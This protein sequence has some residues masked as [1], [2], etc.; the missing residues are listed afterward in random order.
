M[1]ET[2][3]G[4]FDAVD[5]GILWSRIVSIADEMAS[6]LV[7]TSFSTM[8]RESG[9]FSVMLFDGQ[10]R[11]LAQGA[12]GVPS[13]T[14]TGPSTIKGILDIIPAS[15]LR[16]GDVVIT[17]DPWIGTGHVYDINV[18][19]PVFHKGRIVGYCLTVSHLADVGG[20]PGYGADARDV[21]E[22]GFSLPP[23][24]LFQEGV[25]NSFVVDFFKRNVRFEDLVLG[26]L[27]SNVAS[28]NVG[29]QGL[30]DILAEYALDD[31]AEVADGIFAL[32]H[33]AITEQLKTVP[34]GTFEAVL[35]VEGVNGVPEIRLQVAVTV[36]EGGFHY[37]FTGTGPIVNRGVNV[38]IC[39]TRA[40]CYFCF[41][42]LVAPDI[43]NNQAVIDFVTLA[44]PD[45][46]ILNALRPNPTGAR[47]IFGH[48]VAPLVFGALA[49]AL[50]GEVQA[51]SG[52]IFQV[53]LRGRSQ[54]GRDFSYIYFT[55][56]GYG[57]FSDLDG[58]SALPG[59]SNMIGGP[60]E[61][62][63]EDTGCFFL[64]KE[65]LPDTGGAGEFQGGNGQIFALRNDTG[66]VV[67]GAFM[68]SRTRLAARGFRGGSPGAHRRIAVDGVL[69]DPKARVELAPGAVI[70]VE[71][72]GGGGFGDPA[73]RSPERIRS[74]LRRG[75]VSRDWVDR[76]YP[77][78]ARDL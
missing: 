4:H 53:N 71:D 25:L 39:Y 13:F 11:F 35:P 70:E 51:D 9:D 15:D 60:V 28:C 73:A 21:Y 6:A 30:C 52:M 46:C 18:L 68:A 1:T 34:K 48:Y 78:Q 72:S 29:A 8:V 20:G 31:V 17:N 40:Y 41:K 10:A 23:I 74:D 44:A 67:N 14:G 62:W 27:Y 22:E 12:V 45:N 56:G 42:V 61:V 37:D 50:P 7:R 47:H 58:R 26:D 55:P 5:I 36:D 24:K 16:D 43:P 75:L 3:A 38:P 32:T 76:N 65:L 59:P 64:R 33:S 63:E 2:F 69:T 54:L 19:K 57:A 66:R 77:A 49:E